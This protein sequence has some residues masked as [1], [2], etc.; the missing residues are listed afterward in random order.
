MYSPITPVT[1]AGHQALQLSTRHGVAVVA[2]HGAHLLSWVPKGHRDVF[3]LSPQALPEPASIRGGVPVCWPWFATQRMP[4]GA[5]QHGPVRN[6]PWRV[7]TV[8]SSDEDEVS[9]TLEPVVQTALDAQFSALAPGL[10]LSL[11]ITLGS[12][13]RQTLHTRNAGAQSFTL[14]QALH[15]YFAVGQATQ[16]GI[17]GLVGL[18]YQERNAP[19]TEVQHAP[20]A[21]DPFTPACDRIYQHEMPND[22]P[23]AD[24]LSGY[25]YTLLDPVWARRVVIETQGSQSVVV[26]NPGSGGARK[27]VDVPDDAWQDFFCIEAANA[28]P[29]AVVLTPGAE[30]SLTQEIGIIF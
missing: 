26:W 28:G 21:L 1:Y 25:R 12:S 5:M 7:R 4:A 13:L 18:R 20:F 29:D 30:H 2:L 10:Q 16:V 8:H 19:N 9:L 17:E 14:T 22:R 27:I 11:R 3:W 6:L 15:T 23:L 24:R